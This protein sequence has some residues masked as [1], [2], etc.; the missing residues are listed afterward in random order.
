MLAP[1]LG[2]HAQL[3]RIRRVTIRLRQ[4]ERPLGQPG[5]DGREQVDVRPHGAAERAGVPVVRHKRE[6][7][8]DWERLRAPRSVVAPLDEFF[9]DPA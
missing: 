2:Q 5:A 6:D 1:G 3:H 9:S 7:G 4:A 8:V